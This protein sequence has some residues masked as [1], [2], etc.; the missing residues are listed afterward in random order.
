MSDALE[1]ATTTIG[2]LL[3][4]SSIVLWSCWI[5]WRSQFWFA[6]QLK[7]LERPTPSLLGLLD[8]VA[9]V[10][11]IGLLE[12]F[13]VSSSGAEPP[14]S[15]PESKPATSLTAIVNQA[16]SPAT[17][18]S[19]EVTDEANTA[20]ESSSE[21][22]QATSSIDTG[23]QFRSGSSQLLGIV[24][25]LIWLIVRF[26]ATPAEL[27]TPLGDLPRATVVGLVAAV[28]FL[29]P[30]LVLQ[31]LLTELIP[32]KHDTLTMMEAS[33]SSGVILAAFFR[34][35][36]AAPIFEEY[37]FRF[38]LLGWM[39][40]IILIFVSLARSS[41]VSE[42]GLKWLLFGGRFPPT[43]ADDLQ[44]A[45]LK[46]AKQLN[47][48]GAPMKNKPKSI[49][50]IGESTGAMWVSLIAISLLFG[51]AHIGQGAAPIPLFFFAMAVGWLYLRTKNIVPA[52]VVHLVLNLWSL[53]L[54][55]VSHF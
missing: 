11:I 7:S 21:S 1:L 13:I 18:R 9:F 48:S 43:S 12:S 6:R 14:A 5:F 44:E 39:H 33:P 15:E 28:L 52:I 42:S 51:S 55:V 35:G 2:W 32:Y 4:I 23:L 34:A 25:F 3:L 54:F 27:G 45:D 26:R 24:V 49:E 47:E 53:S 30:I 38:A 40:R 8:V 17:K 50:Y 31:V 37:F 41:Q 29:P 22:T 10:F 20:E 19:A 36:F 46:D 16:N